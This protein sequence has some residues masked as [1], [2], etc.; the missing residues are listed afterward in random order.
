MAVKQERCTPVLGDRRE[1]LRAIDQ[2]AVIRRSQTQENGRHVGSAKRG[3]KRV[4]QAR[5]LGNLRGYEI[6][7]RGGALFNS[8]RARG[9]GRSIAPAIGR[10]GGVC[11]PVTLRESKGARC[12]RLTSARTDQR[13]SCR[14]LLQ[15]LLPL[16]ER[17]EAVH[18]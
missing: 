14:L 3:S 12:S 11:R 1:C 4:P 18:G 9:H 7:A 16:P 2:G 5:G 15:I 13:R 17:G 6:K 8:V 10:F